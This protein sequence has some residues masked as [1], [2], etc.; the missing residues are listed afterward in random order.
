VVWSED[1]HVVPS[2]GPSR[3]RRARR[4]A[5]RVCQAFNHKKE[6]DTIKFGDGPG[7]FAARDDALMMAFGDGALEALKIALASKPAPSKIYAMEMS[8]SRFPT[9]FG[10]DDKA[11]EQAAKKVF[12][13]NPNA[14]R[15]R[16][17]LEGGKS[18]RMSYSMSGP[19][20]AYFKM[21]GEIKMKDLQR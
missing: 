19:V 17:T 14:D 12:G 7:Y 10:T 16:M 9:L 15:I 6:K 18:L 1:L 4:H 21:I 11:A 5:R 20:I 3:R 13:D 2:L 8:I